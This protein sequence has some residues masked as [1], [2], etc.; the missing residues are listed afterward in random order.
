MDLNKLILGGHSF[1]GLT[2]IFTARKETRVKCIFGYD[3]FLYPISE[4]LEH[5]QIKLEQPQ[6]HIVTEGFIPRIMHYFE[7]DMMEELTKLIDLGKM[8]HQGQLMELKHTNHIH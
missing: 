6:M 3:A 4:E 1:G 8:K 5:G 7:L 2:S